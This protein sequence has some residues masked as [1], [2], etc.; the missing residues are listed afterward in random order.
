MRQS[1]A[2]MDDGDSNWMQYCGVR[3]NAQIVARDDETA[4]PHDDVD[5][6]QPAFSFEFGRYREKVRELESQRDERASTDLK[7]EE[8][9]KEALRDLKGAQEAE[10]VAAEVEARAKR[11]AQE[12][13]QREERERR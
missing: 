13:R 9:E 8:E 1:S 2:R 5:E 3:L 11:E 12:R 7:Q 6:A 4:L 10:R